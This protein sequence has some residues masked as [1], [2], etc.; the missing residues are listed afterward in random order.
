MK[1]DITYRSEEEV[2]A[3]FKRLLEAK[4]KRPPSGSKRQP[5]RCRYIRVA[6]C[7]Y[8]IEAVD[9]AVMVRLSNPDRLA[10]MD[11]HRAAV[12]AQHVRAATHVVH[13]N[14]AAAE[15]RGSVVGEY[16]AAV[17]WREEHQVPEGE[18]GQAA[19]AQDPAGEFLENADKRGLVY[20]AVAEVWGERCSTYEPECFTCMAWREF[21]DMGGRGERGS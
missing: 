14:M 12:F 13:A 2:E 6:R 3:G 4:R 19:V 11:E 16:Y 21:D 1:F 10:F 18:Q 7:D 5:T 8:E 20:A 15:N 9:D 17:L